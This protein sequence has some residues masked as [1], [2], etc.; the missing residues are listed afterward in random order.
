M[1]K[2]ISAL[3]L[4]AIP[5]IGFAQTA[6]DAYQLSRSDLRG[7]ARFMS[8]AGAFGALGGDLSSLNQNPAGIGVYRKNEIGFTLDIDMQSVKAPF[9]ANDNAT[10]VQNTTSQTKA[11][12]P[13]VG[14]VGVAYTGSEVMPV[15]QWGFSYGRT[16]SFN[17]RYSGTLDMNG[18]IS[19]LIAGY[20]TADGYTTDALTADKYGNNY[21][22]AGH[23]PWMSMLAYNSYMINPLA[24]NMNQYNG[25]WLD[26]T[27]YGIAD[28]DVEEKGFVDE[29]EINF[30]GNFTNSIYWGVGVGITDIDYSRYVYYKEYMTGALTPVSENGAIVAGAPDFDNEAQ[31]GLESRQRISGTGVNVKAGLIYRPINEFRIG[32]AVHSPT[33]YN[34]NQVHDGTVDYNYG[35]NVVRADYTQTPTDSYGWKLR[36]PWRLM[37][38]A[39]TVIGGRGIVSLDYEYRPYQN[40][41]T[42]FDDGYSC[43]DVNN[44]IKSYYKAANIIRLGG[45]FRVTP[46]F[47]IRAG[48]ALE[49]CPTTTEFKNDQMYVYTSN[50]DDT[51]TSPSFSVD[52][53]TQYI[54]C[55]IG[56]HWK[57]FYAD[58][59]Y[60]H[61]SHTSEFHPY[62]GDNGYTANP[63]IAEVKESNNNIVLSVGFKF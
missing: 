3:L 9:L 49:S 36:T 47:S 21:W 17:R 16:A 33:Y 24:S 29:Y 42:K 55:G 12:V 8:M 59:A 27:T 39:A 32:L 63:S 50:P 13:N 56:Y 26:G 2:R 10:W 25:L 43:T 37:A 35:D 11:L 28:F 62:T 4:A 57:S 51:G 30:G 53:K 44:D 15:F 61:R 41:T 60:V 23:A 5:M 7:T 54:T 14:Y 48:Y 31:V 19:N 58:A 38:S 22:G 52:D 45:E 1:N 20:T 18:S 6:F 34:L 46:N 40:M